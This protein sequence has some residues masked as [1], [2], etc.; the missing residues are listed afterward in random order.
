[1]KDNLKKKKTQD[2]SDMLSLRDIIDTFV[3]NWKWF[4]ISVIICLLASRLYLAT[5]PKI[6]KRSAVM[7]V[8]DDSGSG[9]TSSRSRGGTDALMQLNGVVMGSSVKNEVY[10][11]QSH[12]I[13]KQVVRN[14]NLDVYYSYKHHLQTRNLYNVKPFVVEF[15]SADV[16]TLVPYSFQVELDGTRAHI[17]NF[18]MPQKEEEEQANVDILVELGTPFRLPA[19]Q[20]ELRLVPNEKYL[21]EFNGKRI[22]VT[23]TTVEAAAYSYG[24]GLAAGELDKESTLVGITYTDQDI[25]RAEDIINAVLEAYR[26]NIIDDKNRIAQSTAAFIDE[27]IGIISRELSKVE[28]DLAD[29]KQRNRLVDVKSDANNFLQQSSQARQRSILLESQVSVVQYLLDYLRDASK[30]NNLIPTLSGLTDQG[31]QSQIMRYNE[32]MLERNRLIQNTG[33]GTPRIRQA[34]QNLEQMRQTIIASTEAH[35]SSLNVQ[36]IRSKQEESSRD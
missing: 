5:K 2:V 29:F 26:Q 33:E 27:R 13:M 24:A 7:L 34:D 16:E 20:G 11:L 10:I 23:H 35:L 18:T 4:V 22:N 1:M 30:G 21:S 12:Q 17:T 14:L 36:L 31:I 9:S 15:D 19:T 32:L 3:Y 28:G 6:Y 25:S 8:K